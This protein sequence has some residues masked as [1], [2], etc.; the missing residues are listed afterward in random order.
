MT[1]TPKAW[2]GKRAKRAARR[3]GGYSVEKALE[4]IGAVAKD[5]KAVA[6]AAVVKQPT[7]SAA[8]KARA[9]AADDFARSVMVTIRGLEEHGHSLRGVAQWLND[10]GVETRTG[11]AWSA[12][13]VR[14]IKLRVAALDPVEPGYPPELIACVKE[15]AIVNLRM[16]DE[17]IEAIEAAGFIHPN[18]GAWTDDDINAM[19][20]HAMAQNSC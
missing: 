11:A 9:A 15:L 5:I 14:D 2:L 1:T 6:K 12:K 16:N 7:V 13:T 4:I 18:G 19:L 20:E 17:I 3:E 10:L 8:N